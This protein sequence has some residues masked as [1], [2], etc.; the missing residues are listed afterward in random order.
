MQAEVESDGTKAAVTYETF[1][2]WCKNTTQTKYES[3]IQ[4]GDEI[5][6]LSA[7]IADKTSE[8][9][10]AERD[11]LE[12]KAAV[13]MSTKELQDETLNFQYLKANYSK[14]EA[15]MKKAVSSLQ[16]AIAAMKKKKGAIGKYSG[17]LAVRKTIA[18]SLAVADALSL[19]SPPKRQAMSA[20]LQEDPADAT[21]TYHSDDIVKMLEDLEK[22]FT[23]Q[24]SA[25]DTEWAKTDTSHKDMA[26]SISKS[27]ETKTNEIGTR[28]IK[29]DTLS[30]EIGDAKGSLV[31]AQVL[32][33]DDQTYMKDMTTQCETAA[34]AWDQQSKMRSDEIEAIT[35][36]V[37]ILKGKVTPATE[38]VVRALLLSKNATLKV[39]SKPAVA[40]S[41]KPQD[42]K[43]VV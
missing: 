43:S 3:I 39:A 20:L 14:K 40:R 6:T 22:Q 26:E 15:D 4:G 17:L 21:Y 2:C 32:L 7:T 18:K 27:I 5:G 9:V 13:E 29:I 30:S 28:E 31:D 1:A 23:E 24:K 19:I 16:A 35:T 34:A 12:L 37:Q 8:K 33:R 38:K 42:R 41:A 11:V 10:M 36:A 25:L